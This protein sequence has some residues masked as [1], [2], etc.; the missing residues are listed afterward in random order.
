MTFS[1]NV[2]TIIEVFVVAKLSI[3]PPDDVFS[4]FCEEG[5]DKIGVRA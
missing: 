4:L 2:L 3:N 5:T 1:R